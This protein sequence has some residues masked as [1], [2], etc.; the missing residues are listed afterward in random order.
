MPDGRPF[1]ADEDYTP[2]KPLPVPGGGIQIHSTRGT[3]A[4]TWWSAR[5]LDTLT[6]LGVG[7]RLSRGRTYARSGQIVSL[8]VAAGAAV[9]L[10]QGTRPKPYTVRIGV[11]TWDKSEWTRVE[12]ALVDDA[13]YAAALLAG[14]MP[15]EIEELL[16]GL[17]LALFPESG[18]TDL[19]MDCTCPDVTVPCKH[20]AAAFYLLAERFDADP[21]EILALRGRDRETLLEN[22]RERRG[23]TRAEIGPSEPSASVPP[24]ADVLDRFWTS[25]PVDTLP[26][27]PPATSPDAVLDQVPELPVRVRG[28]RVTDLLRPAYLR[29]A[30]EP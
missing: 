20:L 27:A 28:K 3:V 7:G 18:A 14:G 15:P 16:G 1:W 9:A 29:M 8:D 19:S 23:T 13:W 6:D 17:G 10:V 2:R 24:L 25:A 22:L 30:D 21:F 26:P 4:R 12:Q 11:R 5:F